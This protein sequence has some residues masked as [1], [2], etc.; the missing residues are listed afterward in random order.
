[1]SSRPV[2]L[3]HSRLF[4]WAGFLFHYRGFLI[5]QVLRLLGCVVLVLLALSGDPLNLPSILIVFGCSLLLS[6]RDLVGTDGSDQMSLTIL[7]GLVISAA[8]SDPFLQSAGLIFI[9]VQSVLSYIVSGVAKALSPKW[10][11]GLAVAQIMN[12]RTYGMEH[13]GNLLNRLPSLINIMLCWVV[14]LTESLFFLVLFIPWPW[15][16]LLLLWGAL[17]H[18]VN[19]YIMGLNTF[20]WSFVATYPSMI[21]LNHVA[22]YSVSKHIEP[23]IIGALIAVV[24]LPIFWPARLLGRRPPA[25]EGY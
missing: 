10:R 2:V 9:G 13:I 12:T 23:F 19:A 25:D 5:L 8:T 22:R 18:V 24:S 14:I 21:Y 15:A 4:S 1:M 6:F 3:K 7:G 11:S 17:F 16:C 20:L